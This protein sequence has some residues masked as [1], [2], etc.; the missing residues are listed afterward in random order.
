L[1][2]QSTYKNLISPSSLE[3]ALDL[4]F[5]F[6]KF[7]YLEETMGYI[8]TGDFGDSDKPVELI[9]EMGVSMDD[10]GGVLDYNLQQRVWRSRDKLDTKD[11]SRLDD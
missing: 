11:W 4:L 7:P 10:N 6:L 5:S 8:A 2:V 3:Q 1:F 9:R